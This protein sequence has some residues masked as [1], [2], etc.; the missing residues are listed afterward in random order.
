MRMITVAAF[1]VGWMPLVAAHT[2]L[3]QT[4]PSCDRAS[5]TE[6]QRQSVDERLAKE[7]GFLKNQGFDSADQTRFSALEKGR[8][9]SFRAD[10]TA[11]VDYARVAAC[12]LACDHV[13]MELSNASGAL[14]ESPEKQPVVILNGAVP[15]T[16][17]YVVTLSAPGCQQDACGVGLTIVRKATPASP[18]PPAP[19]AV[20]LEPPPAPQATFSTYDNYDMIGGDLRKIQKVEHDACAFACRTD[21]RCVAYS[22][23]KWNKWCFTKDAASEL[24]FTARSL[25]ALREGAVSPTFAAGDVYF[26]RFR[27]KGFPKQSQPKQLTDTFEKCEAL[28]SETDW[29]AAFTYFKSTDECQRYR[30]TG[31]YFSNSNADSGAKRQEVDKQ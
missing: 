1:V 22:Y 31:E 3:A 5:A 18:T 26:E 21:A 25:T 10:L 2:S 20:R 11:G 17:N 12:G 30:G 29:C 15:E 14:A 28:C 6:C 9:E 24:V 16:G 27:N 13:R 7:V 19:A 8:A 4:P 23:D